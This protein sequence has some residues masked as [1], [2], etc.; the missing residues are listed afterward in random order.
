MATAK[1]NK[2][3]TEIEKARERLMEQQTRL[4]ELESKKTELENLEIVDIVRGMSIP[5]D[6]LAAVLQSLKGTA[7]PTRPT[8]GQADPKSKAPPRIKSG[9]DE[10]D[11]D[12]E[13]ETE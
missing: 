3:Q 10:S 13:E 12:E 5:L 8:S 4:R 9:I 11:I 2:V 6:D 7:I 1:I